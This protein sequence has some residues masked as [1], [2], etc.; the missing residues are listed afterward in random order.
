MILGLILVPGGWDQITYKTIHKGWNM[1]WCY[2]INV[3]QHASGRKRGADMSEAEGNH[4]YNGQ[5]RLKQDLPPPEPKYYKFMVGLTD[6]TVTTFTVW[7]EYCHHYK[8]PW[9]LRQVMRCHAIQA[10][11]YDDDTIQ[12]ITLLIIGYGHQYFRQAL[13]P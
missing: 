4:S 5:I 8:L 13:M 6:Y 12:G 10:D 2:F 1:L 11:I 9:K 7:G 3:P